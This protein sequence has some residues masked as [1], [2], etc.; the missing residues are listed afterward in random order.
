VDDVS[1][2][3]GVLFEVLRVDG[4]DKEIND[5]EYADP[6]EGYDFLVTGH[7]TF[8][9]RAGGRPQRA[10]SPKPATKWWPPSNGPY[11]HQLFVEVNGR[12]WSEI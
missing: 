8:G 2:G 6:P 10:S 7:E 11:Q 3:R 4:M 12:V 1:D 5:A 9:R